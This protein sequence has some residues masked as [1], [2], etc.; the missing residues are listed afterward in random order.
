M[1]WKA[2]AWITTAGLLLGSAFY[3]GHHYA[4]IKAELEYNR[5]VADAEKK[6]RAKEE[7]LAKTMLV[8]DKEGYAKLIEKNKLL[9]SSAISLNTTINSLR[10]SAASIGCEISE[11]A[12]LGNATGKPGLVRATGLD[13]IAEAGEGIDILAARGKQCAVKLTACQQIIQGDRD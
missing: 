13:D 4:G 9:E 11:P 1:Q 10:K 3:C 7:E 5:G 2:I 8:I 12:S 6:Q